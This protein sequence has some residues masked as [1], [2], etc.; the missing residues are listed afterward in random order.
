MITTPRKAASPY[1]NE[2]VRFTN[3]LRTV[4]ERLTSPSRVEFPFSFFLFPS[5]ATPP[6]MR[7]T[8]ASGYSPEEQE[9]AG[10]WHAGVPTNDRA[11]QPFWRGRS[12]ARRRSSMIAPERCTGR[13]IFFSP[14]LVL[15]EVCGGEKTEKALLS[16]L[17]VAC[18]QGKDY[19]ERNLWQGLG[20]CGTADGSRDT[21][22]VT[23]P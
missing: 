20:E 16:A 18:G 11:S 22:A 14:C 12:L 8:P 13:G 15:S 7:I 21:S 23:S 17:D 19:D 1:T 4:N 3:P 5:P 9:Q 6:Q 10:R 2:N